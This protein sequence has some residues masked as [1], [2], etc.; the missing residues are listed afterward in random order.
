VG[1]T[2]S[3]ELAALQG[4][5][6]RSGERFGEQAAALGALLWA[7]LLP[8]RVFR[9]PGE[10]L[11]ALAVACVVPLGVSVACRAMGDDGHEA[12]ALQRLL[13]VAA[14]FG[15]ASFVPG[16]GA[17]AGAL[18]GVWMFATIAVALR[19]WQRLAVRGP[20]PLAL[21][22]VDLG[23]LYLPVGGAW[24]LASRAGFSPMGFFEPIVLYTAAHFHYAGFAAVVVMAGVPLVAVGI[25]VSRALESPSAVVLGAGMLV[26]A[27]LL[28]R[29]GL[30]RLRSETGWARVS[31]ALLCVA[32]L[33]LVLSMGFAVAFAMTGSAGR[34]APGGRISFH[35][36]A[37]VHGAANALGF[38]LCA[39]LAFAL[40]GPPPAHGVVRFT[41]PQLFARGFVGVD[42]FDRAGAVDASRPVRGQLDHLDDFARE[43]FDPARVDPRVRAFYERTAAHALRAEAVWHAPFGAPAV[44]FRCAARG[45]LGQLELPLRDEQGE[46]VH[47]RFFALD[48][49]RDGRAGARG[50]V[51]AY[52]EGEAARA[53]Y[54]AAYAAQPGRGGTYLSCAFPLPFASL[55]GLLRF[56][57]GARAG[58]LSLTSE[59]RGDDAGMFLVTPLG[60]LRLPMWERID[61]WA[62]GDSLRAEHRVRILG[63]RCVT[64][65]Y[66]LT[67]VGA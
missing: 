6:A 27:W 17:L 46:T 54:V 53:N 31:G 35:L 60:A 19:G 58:G 13:A 64:L 21:L 26:A 65:S 43:G 51:R 12:R 37:A 47:T 14:P 2:A 10:A 23:H 41:R 11:V 7:A 56:E 18:A 36:M 63:L 33:S 1:S 30:R 66:A 59:R 24:L 57:Q 67:R 8:E 38:A 28:L 42:F 62:D 25:T 32:G 3:P 4:D 52:G 29:E 44:L 16:V 22:A 50:Y 55:L 48:D 61:V 34:A 5:R 9:D 49:A 45:L 40:R 15:L 39:L 20:A